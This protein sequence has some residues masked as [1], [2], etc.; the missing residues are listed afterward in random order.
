[1]REIYNSCAG[2]ALKKDFGLK[3]KICRAAVSSMS[4]VAE[5]LVRKSDR[6]FSHFFDV[7]R[8]SAVEVQSLRYVALDVGYL[9]PRDFQRLHKMAQDT[10]SLIGGLTSYLR[11][12][13][14]KDIPDYRRNDGPRTSDSGHVDK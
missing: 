1:M 11:H 4:N 14:R 2:G 12:D 13:L 7:A 9:T 10:A 5:G 8:G 6:D 3:D